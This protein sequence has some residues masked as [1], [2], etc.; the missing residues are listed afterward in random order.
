M[1]KGSK[2]K[3]LKGIT[4]KMKDRKIVQKNLRTGHITWTEIFHGKNLK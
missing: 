4:K 1:S 2:L 3:F